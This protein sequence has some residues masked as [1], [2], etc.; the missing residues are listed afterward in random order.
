[1]YM[2]T[3][4]NNDRVKEREKNLKQIGG[5]TTFCGLAFKTKYTRIYAQLV[6]RWSHKSGKV[7]KHF[8]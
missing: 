3:V 7:V 4:F 6:R 8:I 1:M 5:K 2:V